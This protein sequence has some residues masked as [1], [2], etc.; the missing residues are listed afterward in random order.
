MADNFL[1]TSLKALIHERIGAT[2]T[3]AHSDLESLI[4]NLTS[5]FDIWEYRKEIAKAIIS[6][7]KLCDVIPEV[8]RQYR[9]I[10]YDGVLFLL[11]NLSEKRFI[12]LV[13]RQLLLGKDIPPEQRLIELARE[14]PTLHKLGQVIA[15]NRDVEFR[16][17]KW[18]IHLENDTSGADVKPFLKTI[19]EE[20]GNASAIETGD[21]ILAEASVA[22]VVPFKGQAPDTGQRYHGV[23]KLLKP[24]VEEYLHEEMALLDG[25]AHYYDKNREIYL[26]KNFRFIETF[27]DVKESLMRE[28]HLSGEQANLKEA[29]TFYREDP[30]TKIPALYPFSTKK[31]TAME[32][33]RGVKITDTP[34]SK[35]Q[36][37]RLAKRL[38]ISLVIRPLFSL[39]E[40]TIFHGDPHG[41]N[42]FA[43]PLENGEHIIAL[44]DWSL[45]GK[46]TKTQR[47]NI[48]RLYLSVLTG[49]KEQ[50]YQILAAL[51]ED[52]LG[53]S[54]GLSKRT[55][56][57][58]HEFFKDD[59]N[60]MPGQLMKR[61]FFLINRTA[62]QGIKF[63]AD[64]LLLRKAIFTLE[65]L[66]YELD[67]A[68]DIDRC[69]FA[70]LGQ[71]L[72]EEL[73]LRWF[74]LWFP[75]FDSAQHY[76]SLLS[77]MEL[78]ELMNKLAAKMFW[79]T[80]S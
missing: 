45:A 51:S 30:F 63:P 38:F 39:N 21:K 1:L 68:F 8:H 61:T 7:I 28:I 60:R 73:P 22:A 67:P 44:L 32:R 75:L 52:S 79:R 33:I 27:R 74:Y 6:E 47:S 62:E 54:S 19:V 2:E 53:A 50:I 77:N 40:V 18:L 71:L 36:K 59:G 17:R 34:L 10:V 13:V 25:L 55:R 24:H 35:E 20:I 70:F 76:K 48:L 29:Y 72:S 26:L 23:V 65:G 64:L 14:L 11:S 9:P 31:M 15:R 12:Q 57:S 4:A 43:I 80:A 42:I 3:P 49:D 5:E 56:Q 46:L 58:I 66:L 16:F 78:L 41:G 69:L 37:E